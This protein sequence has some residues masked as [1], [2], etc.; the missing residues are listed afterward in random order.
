MTN[1]I[2]AFVGCQN[3]DCAVEVSYPL[4]LVRMFKGKPIC[5]ECWEGS[6]TESTAH[7]DDLLPV[8]IKD[9]KE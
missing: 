1:K 9:L 8:R 7:W 6:Q 2:Q 4:D 5:R 3:Y